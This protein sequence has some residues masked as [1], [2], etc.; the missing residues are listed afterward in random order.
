[1]V[2]LPVAIA[3]LPVNSAMVS[4]GPPLLVRG[5]RRGSPEI[6]PLVIDPSCTRLLVD[7]AG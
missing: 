6:A 7:E 1:M 4:V 5:P 3:G 2:A